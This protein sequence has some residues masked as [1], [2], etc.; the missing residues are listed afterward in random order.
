[1][2]ETV[3]VALCELSVF[4]FSQ[5]VGIL[6][7][8]RPVNGVINR[9]TFQRILE[10]LPRY[11]HN[12][13][14]FLFPNSKSRYPRKNKYDGKDGSKEFH[15]KDSSQPRN[16]RADESARVTQNKNQKRPLS[17]KLTQD[18]I[19]KNAES[20]VEI[21]QSTDENGPIADKLMKNNRTRKNAVI[22]VGMTQKM[23]PNRKLPNRLLKDNPI[24][25]KWKGKK[26]KKRKG[27]PK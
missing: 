14:N 6:E 25:K 5:C 21:T 22:S 15:D 8:W 16:T 7:N 11:S 18:A 17:N 3:I 4:R 10:Q 27:K 24:R 23:N 20:S 9:S 19:A 13:Q 1:M 26:Q 12:W 2:K